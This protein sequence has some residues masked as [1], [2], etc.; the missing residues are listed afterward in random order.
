MPRA[1]V[2]WVLALRV[3]AAWAASQRQNGLVGRDQRCFVGQGGRHD[4]AIS[5]AIS[6]A[7]GVSRRRGAVRGAL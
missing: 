4:D 1:S 2:E 5:L 3:D 6:Q 7:D